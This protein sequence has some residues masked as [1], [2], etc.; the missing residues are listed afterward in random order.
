MTIRV[1]R[2]LS[3]HRNDFENTLIP[4]NTGWQQRSA[5]RPRPLRA[6]AAGAEDGLRGVYTLDLIDVCWVEGRG[7]SAEGEEVAMCGGQGVFV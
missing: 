1:P 4:R 3:P 7:E 2:S 5:E 6:A